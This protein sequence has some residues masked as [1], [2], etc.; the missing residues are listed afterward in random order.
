MKSR[1][2][3]IAIVCL[4]LLALLVLLPATNDTVL[5][6]NNAF[7]FQGQYTAP[8]CGPRHDITIGPNTRTID[9]VASTV[10]VNDIVLSCT[11]EVR[12]S[13][14]RIRA[15]AQ[16]PFTTHPAVIS[17]RARIRWKSVR[18]VGKRC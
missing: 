10:P 14:S 1:L 5:A 2:L 7:T 8:A 11:T 4:V 15:Q 3:A 9:V 12:S 16:N 17:R 13:L 18:L 6:D